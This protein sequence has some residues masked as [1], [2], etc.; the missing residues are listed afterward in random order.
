MKI[1]QNKIIII[2]LILGS[3]ITTLSAQEINTLHFMKGVPQSDI[4]NPALHNDSTKLVIGLPGLSGVNYSLNS[5]FAVN[6]LLH[7]G[8]GLLADSLVLD[9]EKFN[10]S[11]ST[12]NT[13]SQQLGVPIL[14]L[15]YHSKKSFFSLT[16]SEKAMANLS[17][18]KSLITFL[19]DGNASFMGQNYDLGGLKMNA[20][21]Y[22][23]FA[24]GY[25]TSM[26]NNRLTIGLRAKVLF[27]KFAVQTEKMNLKVETAADGS[28]I[29]LNSDIKINMSSPLSA[30]YDQDGY[31][32]GMKDFEFK[33]VDYMTETGNK[34][35][36]FD[37]GAV[38]RLTPKILLSA[39]LVDI[40]KINFSNNL[41]N[42][43]Q[44]ASYNWEGIDFS[45]SIDTKADDY[46]NPSDLIET[47]TNKL[48]DT[49]RPKNTDFS[50]E[51]FGMNIPAKIFFGG[52]YDIS[53]NFNVGI[54]DRFYKSGDYSQNSITLS[55]N[56][57][58]G[59]FFSLTGSYS[60]I[61]NSNNNLGIGMALQLGFLQ[62]YLVNDNVLAFV[63]P[64]KVEV[65][66][67]RFGLNL[68]FGRKN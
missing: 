34:G 66:N 12:S 53:R 39:S 42:L 29:N 1:F 52:T 15:G 51:A 37:F 55:A 26:L 8:T 20:F 63:D 25:S 21:Q 10:N 27:G 64:A 49:F 48:T 68:L 14:Y 62:L 35:F 5:G 7:K 24:L 4:F 61:G 59:K 57:M 16:V 56:A 3:V 54:L 13:I 41:L 60:M 18:D 58:M 40:G 2:G 65:V 30:E 46:V 67:M 33:P 19:K 9:L 22:S 45:K 32:S 28:Y 38:Y 44:A 17:F 43:T 31:F 23:E 11:L 50:S 36:A 6:N 47:E